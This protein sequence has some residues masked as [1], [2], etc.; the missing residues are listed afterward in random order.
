V[1]VVASSGVKTASR[2]NPYICSGEY[3]GMTRG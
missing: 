1:N 3:L 2:Q